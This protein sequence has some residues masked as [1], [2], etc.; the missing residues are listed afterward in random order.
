MKEDM[1][2]LVAYDGS[3]HAK[4]AL[5]ES[6][7]LA[8]KFSGFLT[9]LHCCWFESDQASILLLKDVKGIL[10][11]AS[12]NHEYK[13]IR[14]NNPSTTILQIAEEGG[15]DMIVLGSRG[16][17]GARALILGSVSNKVASEATIPILIVK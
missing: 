14:T 9:L 3:D 11:A 10:E 8:Q 2:I 5:T 17:G 7:Q 4:R 12:V 16:L 1:K 15:Y 13:S 6:I